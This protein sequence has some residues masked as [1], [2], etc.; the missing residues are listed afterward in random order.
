[1]D[2]LVISDLAKLLGGFRGHQMLTQKLVIIS[3]RDYAL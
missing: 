2:G 3:K 1:M